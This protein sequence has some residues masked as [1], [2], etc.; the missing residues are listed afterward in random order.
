MRFEN[1]DIK[2]EEEA[3]HQIVNMLDKNM[4]VEAGAGAG[5]TY[6]IV[7]R[8]T[9]MLMH[10]YWPGEIVVITFTNAA[11]EELRGRIAKRVRKESLSNE[12]LKEKLSHLDEM[13][14]STIHSFCNVLLKEQS[15]AAGL[16]IDISIIDEKEE[17]KIKY[18]YLNYY[19]AKLSEDEWDKLCPEIKGKKAEK[20]TIREYIE[21]IY[22]NLLK[23]P[24]NVNVILGNAT[25]GEPLQNFVDK[26]TGIVKT[27]ETIERIQ[28][29]NQKILEQVNKL[30]LNPQDRH[31]SFDTLNNETKL[32]KKSF[33]DYYQLIEA[34][35]FLE[36]D[37][38]FYEAV[39]SHK[40]PSYIKEGASAKFYDKENINKAN[41]E[42][43]DFIIGEYSFDINLTGGQ[44][45]SEIVKTIGDIFENNSKLDLCRH[46]I[47]AADLYKSN[48]PRNLV[49]ND[50]LLQLTRDLICNEVDDRA[51]RYFS[52]KYKSF[53]VDEFQD[54]DSIQADF[55]YRLASDL[56]ASDSDKLR[57]GALFVVGDPKQSIYR[58]RGAQPEIYFQIKERMQK[59]ENAV[60]YELKKNF[61]TNEILIEWINRKFEEADGMH[62]NED[63]QNI[64]YIVDEKHKYMPMLPV[65]KVAG[66]SDKLLVGAYRYDTADSYVKDTSFGEGEKETND[67]KY[68]P[69]TYD[70]Y[71]DVE[72]VVQLIQNLV[73]GEF[74]ITDYDKNNV[75]FARKIEPRDILLMTHGKSNMNEYL[76]RLKKS[77]ISVRFDGNTS[78]KKDV[79]L[80]VY[81]RI[82]KHLINPKD[83]F[84]RMAA[85]EAIRVT[86][87]CKD[88]SD[89]DLYVDYLLDSLRKGC[90]G[91]GPYG[92]A[93]YLVKQLSALVM[94]DMDISYI[95]INTSL[96]HIRQMIEYLFQN[97]H[98]NGMKLIE[99]MEEYISNVVEHE[100]SLEENPN[101]IRFMNLH[102]TKG[103]EGKIVIIADRDGILWQKK[104]SDYRKDNDYY[105]GYKIGNR[106][107]SAASSNTELEAKFVAEG[108]AE[109]HRIEYV[110]VTRAEQVVIF[111]NT[112]K[113][114]CVFANRVVDGKKGTMADGFDYK[115]WELPSIKEKICQ[116][117]SYERDVKGTVYDVSRDSYTSLETVDTDSRRRPL[118]EKQSPSGL[119]VPDT[120]REMRK[121]FIKDSLAAGLTLEGEKSPL[122]KR[123]MDNHVGNVLHRTMELLVGRYSTSESEERLRQ[124]VNNCVSQAIYENIKDLAI[125]KKYTIEEVREFIIQCG[126]SFIQWWRFEENGLLSSIDNI[127][128][129]LPFSYYDASENDNEVFMKGNADLLVKKQDGSVLLFDYK[130]DND[131]LIP[132][133]NISDV[134]LE[135]YGPQLEVYRKMIMKLMGCEKEQIKV[136]II[137][138]SQKDTN[139]KILEDKVVRLRCTEI[140]LDQFHKVQIDGNK[141]GINEMSPETPLYSMGNKGV[142]KEFVR[143]CEANPDIIDDEMLCKLMS[144]E[145]G[146]KKFGIG[147]KYPLLVE[148][149]GKSDDEIKVLRRSPAR[150]YNASDV[151][152]CIRE[153]RFLVTKEW[154][155]NDR[156][157]NL[158]KLICWMDE[159]L[160][161]G[162]IEQYFDDYK[163]RKVLPELKVGSAST[164]E[165]FFADCIVPTLIPKE[166]AMAWHNMLMEYINRDDAV[167]LLRRYE[168]GSKKGGRWNTRR[169]AMTRFADGFRYVFV[170]NFEAHEIYNMAFKG[171]VPTAKEFADL[172]NK[173][174]YP[175]HY[176]NGKSKSCEEIDIS[177]YPHIGTVRS[178]VLNESKYY[179]AH[180]HSV[181]ETDYFEEESGTIISKAEINEIA[182]RGELS[183]W[184]VDE[185]YPIRQYDYSLSDRQ[186]AYVVA[187]FLRFVDP[188]NYFLT[189]IKAL[190]SI[191]K[192]TWNQN[193]GEYPEL[194]KYVSSIY[195]QRFGE[196]CINS[197]CKKAMTVPKKVNISECGNIEIGISYGAAPQKGSK[198]KKNINKPS[199]K[200]SDNKGQRNKALEVHSNTSSNVPIILE[201]QDVI[202]FKKM[203]L[204]NKKARFKITFKDGRVEMKNWTAK[205]FTEKSDVLN[206]IR[207]KTWW[208]EKDKLGIVKVEVFIGH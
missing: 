15:I 69:A 48:V 106:I 30:I 107:W 16:P 131:Y 191:K 108:K 166:N 186:K 170:S 144:T 26:M 45:I 77:G 94:K 145:Y 139:G 85:K 133:R 184:S 62:G 70:L 7:E 175:M 115:L 96:T 164:I 129:E 156:C 130:S 181:N 75:P 112:V 148:I 119:E 28:R 177:A 147:K 207:S 10:E 32:L 146:S 58:F 118:Y 52:T 18:K 2:T 51:C 23:Q 29:I 189:P 93:E 65:K 180:I 63:V 17:R 197:F 47:K 88:E 154:Y 124:L 67:S 22:F 195:E 185:G 78:L 66:G 27:N 12:S 60:V 25:D 169:S 102:K 174:K 151:C 178:G 86:N 36:A 41:D 142:V 158:Q 121:S 97:E 183:D 113:N 138:F 105:P 38:L 13:N 160:E 116:K 198:N 109:F 80:H 8:I 95:E 149:T 117:F 83:R 159:V 14:I 91:M 196:S 49:T 87:L 173:H 161:R 204:I 90:Q 187:H 57:D 59:Q 125:S 194:I 64:M 37:K 157:K 201:P 203:L 137:S 167:F 110:A 39:V 122:M 132:E 136:Y 82:Y 200:K 134:F 150:Y 103:L 199:E 208:R 155:N 73:N 44:K 202:E 19:L 152:L 9:S 54:T 168:N 24:D 74:E 21:Q 11:A 98:G 53:F 123:P 143:R 188:L 3:R 79:M 104:M 50:K 84:F 190:T 114:G 43:A 206:N 92:I 55:I 120:K 172:L 192:I 176:D 20:K 101:A 89:F 100:L 193:I 76:T 153:R 171:V 56:E 1:I 135:K 81:C 31:F 162:G 4:F 99:A 35:E 182:P 6:L 42:I 40:R 5:K 141:T 68:V 61:R 128:T 72:D 46:A 34:K 33:E 179:L 127:Y 165:K 163:K 111:M 205:D 140:D 126:Y 71:S